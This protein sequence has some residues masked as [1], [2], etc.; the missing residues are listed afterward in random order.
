[1]D[2]LADIGDVFRNS[3]VPKFRSRTHHE[4]GVIARAVKPFLSLANAD[5]LDFG[6]GS[7]PLAVASFAARY[8]A[9]RVVGSDVV[10]TQTAQLLTLWQTEVG[11]P[12]P[13]NLTL[14]HNEPSS[15][16]AS[17][18]DFDLIYSWSVFEH[19]PSQDIEACFAAVRERMKPNG[20]FHFQIGGLFFSHD[21]GH[22]S[23][24]QP[25]AHLLYSV[26]EIRRAIEANGRT[27]GQQGR[28]WRQ[29]IE[30]NRLTAPDFLR[31]AQRSGLRLHSHELIESPGDPPPELLSIYT[32][33]A[34]K[35]NE[36]R[37]IFTRG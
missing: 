33:E 10:P 15:L 13:S 11:L 20:V 22:L 25:W 4:H 16:P 5:I 32:R 2:S 36:V 12:L 3:K 8:P 34:L 24:K 9:A 30:L 1:M 29:H 23:S 35:T 27:Q 14:L 26:D 19:I 37:A 6:C 7:L 18:G 21:G 31:C 28:E 17:M